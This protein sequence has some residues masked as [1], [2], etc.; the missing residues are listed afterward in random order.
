MVFRAGWVYAAHGRN[1]LQ[2][3]L[4][5]AR[6]SEELRVV[7]DQ[8]GTPTP[9]AWVADATA[10]IV[11]N[12]FLRSGTWHLAPSGS[13]SWHGFAMAIVEHAHARGLVPRKP[14]IVPIATTEYPAPARRPA[15]ETGGQSPRSR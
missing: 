15:P 3:I 12:P 11:A 14:G 7:A 4:R 13:T 10:R 9:A 8:V 6:G 1:F 2:A 5:Q